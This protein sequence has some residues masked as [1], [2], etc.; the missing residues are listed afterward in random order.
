M[1]IAT[2]IIVVAAV[3]LVICLGFWISGIAKNRRERNG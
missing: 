3:V 1:S 2:V